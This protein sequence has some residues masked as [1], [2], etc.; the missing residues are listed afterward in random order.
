MFCILVHAQ[1]AAYIIPGVQHSP[2]MPPQICLVINTLAVPR[3]FP[4]FF[5]VSVLSPHPPVFN[6]LLI[7]FLI[8]AP[9]RRVLP[10]AV[11]SFG[12]ASIA[13]YL[14]AGIPAAGHSFFNIL[15]GDSGTVADGRILSRPLLKPDRHLESLNSVD[16][17]PIIVNHR[18]AGL[19]AEVEAVLSCSIS[20]AV[21][22]HQICHRDIA[23]RL[24]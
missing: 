19:P 23:D 14:A 15:P 6:D 5:P 2:D 8:A 21:L 11:L 16:P 12:F 7:K 22:L 20:D 18:A 4:I 3:D 13:S 17:D 10:G 9:A 1:K 24:A